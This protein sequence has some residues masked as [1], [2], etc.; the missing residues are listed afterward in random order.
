MAMSYAP[1]PI[2]GAGGP[3]RRG[4]LRAGVLALG[5]LTLDLGHVLRLRA[6]SPAPG[7][8]VARARARPKSVIM[9]HLSGGPSH[10]DMYDMKP[11]APSGYRGEFRPIK[12]NVPGMEICELMPRQARVADR[13]AILQGVQFTELHTANEFYSGY[14]WQESPRASAPGEA[15]RPALGSVVSRTRRA[16]S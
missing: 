15:Q 4:A 11:S 3:S 16:R 10:L 13:F 2:A 8:A 12:T 6:E 14:P 7:R 1:G 9:I 5:G